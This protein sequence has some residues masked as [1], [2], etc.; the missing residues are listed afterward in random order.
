MPQRHSLAGLGFALT[1][2]AAFGTS[3]A[4]AKSLLVEGWSPGAVVTMRIGLAA[5]VLLVPTVVSLRGRW[6]VLRRNLPL[7]VGYGLTGVAGCQLAYFY[8][9]THLSVGVALLLEYLAPVLIVGWLW[10]RYR[11]APRRLTL[12]GVG[13][14]VVGLLLVLDVVGGVRI[15]L[16]GVGF[17]L[18][19][20]VCLV[21]YFLLAARVEDALPPL[22]FAGS[23]LV[24]GA[25]VLAAA[26]LTGLLDMTTGATS[27]EISSLTVPWW[28]PVLVLALV[29]AAFAYVLGVAAVRVLGAKVASFVALTE[30]LFAVLF[31][32]LIL[33]ELPTPIQL[34]GGALI[35]AGLVAVRADE[36]G[37]G[38][39]LV[40]E[41]LEI[42]AVPALP[43]QRHTP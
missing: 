10:A 2:A 35:V 42:P 33:A 1:S 4:F 37:A 6:E 40:T 9:V 8:A 18:A 24:V 17:G 31:A 30:V 20:A 25:V 39:A 15:S 27:V 23:G 38:V 29:A 13:L 21:L 3:G 43:A 41:P 34:V 32:W 36:S 12:V 19:A 16:V 22:A 26:G 5:A 11:Q 14:A 7:I 28:A